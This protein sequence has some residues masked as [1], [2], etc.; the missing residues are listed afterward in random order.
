MKKLI[1]C[2]AGMAFFAASLFGQRTI[3][4]T[5]DLKSFKKLDLEFEYP[6]LIKVK[7]WDQPQVKIEGTVDIAL[8]QH[9]DAFEL[10]LSQ[11]GD[12][13]KIKSNIKDMKKWSRNIIFHDSDHDQTM[14]TS[15]DGQTIITGSDGKFKY[16]NGV[17]VDIE[18]IITIPKNLDVRLDARYGMV[19]VLESPRQ[20]EVEARYG[21]IDITIDES[22]LQELEARTQ[23]GQI[24]SD[25]KLPIKVGGEDKMGQWMK[26]QIDLK[27]GHQRM[28]VESQYGN[29]FLRKN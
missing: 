2:L 6:Q 16:K 4:E 15:R 9:D 11:K 20:L 17:L 3:S 13:F 12:W 18:L 14:V 25:L 7:V 26:A 27:K 8:G 21:G 24:F 10:S 29:V 22:E 5:Y 23:W 19:E 28:T 1:F